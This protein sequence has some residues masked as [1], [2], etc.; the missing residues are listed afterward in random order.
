MRAGRPGG[1][2]LAAFLL[3]GGASRGQDSLNVTKVGEVAFWDMAEAIV[4]SS[5]LAYLAAG[6]S[7]LRIV[8]ITNPASPIEVG[9]CDIAGVALNIALWN[10]YA[11]VVMQSYDLIIIDITDPTSPFEVGY[12]DNPAFSSS[13]TDNAGVAAQGNY[14][15]LPSGSDGLRVVDLDN[16]ALPLELAQC[17]IEYARE[18]ALAGNLVYVAGG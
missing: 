8:D 6:E 11:L 17:P 1:M 9:F 15:Y 2:G 3:F 7:G 14:A 13:T 16:P 4:V 12:Y 18:L 5:N 10:S